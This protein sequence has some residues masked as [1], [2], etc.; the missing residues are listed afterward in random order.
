MARGQ[1]S[2]EL[3]VRTKTIFML[4]LHCESFMYRLYILIKTSKSAIIVY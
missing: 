4:I 1:D 2:E 3:D